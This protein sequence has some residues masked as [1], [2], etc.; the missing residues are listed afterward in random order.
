MY[1]TSQK[2]SS[3]GILGWS[4]YSPLGFA[5]LGLLT[6]FPALR[7][8]VGY[9]ILVLLLVGTGFAVNDSYL[10][11]VPSSD[12]TVSLVAIFAAA[13]LFFPFWLPAIFLGWLGKKVAVRVSKIAADDID[14]DLQE[15]RPSRAAHRRRPALKQF[16]DGSA[17]A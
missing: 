2:S 11:L 9:L 17:R 14:A 1:D 5:F 16:Y 3:F 13:V 12:M 15:P 6:L 4:N 8:V 10:H 7:K